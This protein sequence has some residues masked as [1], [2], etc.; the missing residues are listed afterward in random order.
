[1]ENSNPEILVWNPNPTL[2]IYN[3]VGELRRGEVN[4]VD[5]QSHGAGGKGTL[6]VRALKRLDVATQGVA[7]IA[8]HVGE[9]IASMFRDEGLPF[10]LSQVNG[11]TR[12]AIT[13]S[14]R[15][16]T[17]TVLNGLGPKA[18][19]SAWEAHI[20]EVRSLL[21]GARFTTFVLAGRPPL[22]C[23]PAAVRDLCL[24]ATDMGARVVADVATPFL[25]AVLAAR[26]SMVK[27][28]RTEAAE[29]LGGGDDQLSDLSERIQRL[30]AENVV[31]TD[32]PNKVEARFGN[33]EVSVYPPTC[34]LR[35]AVGCGDCFLAGLLDSFRRGDD[36][37]T[38][39]RWASA[40]ASAATETRMPGDF[41]VSRA[42][43]LNASL[44]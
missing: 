44:S 12:S 22:S 24:E 33:E 3:E 25:E 20:A 32:G 16:L 34:R 38:S 31:I 42:E 10:A 36:A 26:P 13:I 37:L 19:D 11:E 7:P 30:G 29:M 39:M 18:D 23:D 5:A 40:V 8:G 1:M 41:S 6:V 15:E 14:D 9:L 27:I 21:C 2:D 35:S 4:A 17:D 43:T 28:N